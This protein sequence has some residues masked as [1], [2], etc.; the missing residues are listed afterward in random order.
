MVGF[1]PPRDRDAYAAVRGFVYQVDLTIERWLALQPRQ[2]LELECGEDIDLISTALAS[3]PEDQQR[4]LEQVK[5]RTGSLTLKTSSAVAALACAV[6]HIAANPEL[7]LSFCFTTNAKVGRERPSPF[8]DRR[9]GIQVWESARQQSIEVG[10]LT[11]ALRGLRSIMRNVRKPPD[12]NDGTWRHY[13]DFLENASD[14]ELV[15]FIRGFQWS[16]EAGEA[17]DLAARIRDS[18]LRGGFARDQREAQQQYLRLF[19]HV[20]KLLSQPGIKRLSVVGRAAQ[21]ALR[22]LGSAD[23]ELLDN[24]VRQLTDLQAD[25]VAIDR[26]VQKIEAAIGPELEERARAHEVSAN[27]KGQPG[28]IFLDVPPTVTHLSQRHQTVQ[29]MADSIRKH[30][31]TTI[32]GSSG[33]GKTQLAVLIARELRT[34]RGW[35]RLRGAGDEKQAC[36][37]LHLALATL[38][39]LEP[40]ANCGEWYNSVCEQMSGALLVIDDLPRLLPDGEL[41]DRLV[42]LVQAC[43]A[44]G[45]QM[46]TTSAS[47]LPNGLSDILDQP[48][49]DQVACPPFADDEARDV[50]LAYGAP[51]HVITPGNVTFLNNI[52][53]QHPVLLNAAAKYLAQASWRFS[54]DGL[55]RLFTGDYAAGVRQETT[56][57]LLQTVEDDDSRELLHRL[58][59]VVGSFDSSEVQTL[60]AV[61]PTISRPDERLN[62]LLGLWLQRDT[63]QRLVVSPLVKPLGGDALTEETKRAAQLAL[64]FGVLRKRVL[65]QSDATH[66]VLYFCGAKAF[67]QAGL[68]L[69]QALQ[70]VLSAE[71]IAQ[72]PMFLSIWH[73]VPLPAEMD[74]GIRIF[75][76]GLQTDVCLKFGRDASYLVDDLDQL[77]SLATETEAWAVFGVAGTV[78]PRLAHSDLMRANRFLGVAFRLLPVAKLPSGEGLVLPEKIVAESLIWGNALAIRSAEDLADWVNTLGQMSPEQRATAFAAE[79]AAEDCLMASNR[80][81]FEESRKPAEDQD[82][83]SALEAYEQFAGKA[84]QLDLKLLWA[85]A[86]HAKMVILAEYCDDLDA[87]I[88]VAQS[89]LSRASSTPEVQFIIRQYI[90]R[91]LFDHDRVSESRDWLAEAL[92]YSA[93]GFPL[94]R[95]DSLLCASNAIGGQDAGRAK[96]YAQEAVDLAKETNRIPN[97]HLVKGLGEL[98]VAEWMA[99]S[100]T[101]AFAAWNEAGQRLLECKDDSDEWKDLFVLYGSITS[102]FSD[103]ARTGEPPRQPS[104]E[105]RPSPTR[106]IFFT[107]N[108][109]RVEQYDEAYRASS[110]PLMLQLTWFAEAVGQDE[111]ATAWAMR[112][113][114]EA[115]ADNAPTVVAALAPQILPNLIASDHYADAV[116][117][118]M[119]A[120]TVSAAVTELRK[121]RKTPNEAGFAVDVDSLLGTKPSESWKQAENVAA[122]LGLLPIAF[123]L[124]HLAIGKSERVSALAEEVAAS[125]RQ[126][127][128]GA[129]DAELWLRAANL[130]EMAFVR[131][132]GF[133]EM[134]KE[135][136]KC[137]HPERGVLQA[138]AYLLATVQEDCPIERGL[139]TQLAMMPFVCEVHATS[140][141]MHRRIILPFAADYWRDVFDK[142]RFR[143]TSPQLV[144]VALDEIAN[145]PEDQRT[146][147]IYQIM[148]D[149]LGVKLQPE[150]ERWIRV[151]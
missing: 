16:P 51:S 25:V 82:W 67:D 6:E 122:C 93:E 141:A 95:F 72:L 104:G 107:R 118:A 23:E 59:L 42:A 38:S 54:N 99:G 81:W 134:I 57:R 8:A 73:S 86:I 124:C 84:L 24:V 148:V 41:A 80:L 120:G 96:E 102:Y 52:A 48:L 33:C 137:D 56:S 31:W 150:A 85:S 147:R 39:Q 9:P 3:V 92:T 87:A 69:V 62:P 49:L 70:S 119:E 29:K 1:S 123:R 91:Q 77:I 10:E 13:R 116:D 98:A 5:H 105:E 36:A 26:R 19:L 136:R 18:L 133:D 128:E 131:R 88:A 117:A 44:H 106:G 113:I 75:I 74:L 138:I 112:G 37:R 115:R 28:P 4:L 50:L 111:C 129:C 109:K 65:D 110:S 46:L 140:S 83:E 71:D 100:V 34:C 130:F 11:S 76:R 125:C 2:F 97:D 142:M 21:L 79:G 145:T 20:F 55:K 89:A 27:I 149:G 103:F 43:S 17:G 22:S 108:P 58:T 143:F 66:A 30:V 47:A 40:A 7:D 12:L 151:D 121:A 64:A 135:S 139:A 94:V 14:D 53:G 90:G 126:V 61:N 101:D 127:T 146:R 60:A 78:G 35:I 15:G 114:D 63:N 132:T 68:I 144:E 32:Q 45:L